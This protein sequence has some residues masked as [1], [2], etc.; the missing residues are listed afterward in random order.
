PEPSKSDLLIGG[1]AAGGMMAES[2]RRAWRSLVISPDGT[3]A[4]CVLDAGWSPKATMPN[5]IALCDARTGKVIRRWGDGGKQT[6]GYEVMALSP[7]GRL[8]ATTEGNDVHLWE[9]VTGKEVRACR[10]HRNEVH[11][12][13][14]SGNGRRLA[15]AGT[16]ATTVIWDLSAPTQGDGD[17]SA[18]WAELVNEDSAKAYPAV[19]RL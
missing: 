2:D 12:M 15:S 11:A 10:G 3:L 8:L 13:A 16:D 17:P 5:R 18:W 14:F 19:W 1:G 4:A 6:R 9:V 7:D